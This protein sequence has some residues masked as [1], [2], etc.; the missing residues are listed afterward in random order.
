MKRHHLRTLQALYAHPLQHGVRVSRVEA[1]FHALGAECT[2]LK[3]R[4]L[5]IRLPDGQE[6]WIRLGCG[7][8]KPDLDADSVM[9]LRHFLSEA[10]ITPDHP[11]TSEPSPRGDQSTRLVLHLNHHRTDVYRLEGEEVDHAV[12]RP[13]GLWGSGERL[14]HRHDR[15]LEGQRAPRDNDYL[16]RITAAMAEADAVLMLGHGTGESD[17]RAILLAYVRTH[18]G[19]LLEKIVGVET[20][21][22]AG[23]SEDALLAIAREHFGNLP[24]R[25]PLVAAGQEVS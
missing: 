25:R 22:D 16:A 9:R 11:E 15:D 2:V 3:E 6:T 12:L 7:V 8:H 23:M 17:M 21:D 18:R 10:G 1:M 24:S 19:D 14:T 20:I 5:K 4:R 13:H